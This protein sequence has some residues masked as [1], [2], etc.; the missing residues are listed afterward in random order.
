MKP[1]I[2]KHVSNN[3]L[4]RIDLNKLCSHLFTNIHFYYT[5]T[6]LLILSFLYKVKCEESY[7]V[8]PESGNITKNPLYKCSYKRFKTFTHS[9]HLRLL[10]IRQDFCRFFIMGRIPCCRL[11]RIKLFN[12]LDHLF[13]QRRR[14]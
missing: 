5:L 12:I 13:G 9:L 8:D 4:F 2:S 1:S 6:N 10:Y 14:C 11:I 3:R 7:G